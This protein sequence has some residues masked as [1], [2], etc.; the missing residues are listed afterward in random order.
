LLFP[1]FFLL[2]EFKKNIP[3]ACVIGRYGFFLYFTAKALIVQNKYYE[4]HTP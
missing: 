4:K 3:D 2:K 1:A